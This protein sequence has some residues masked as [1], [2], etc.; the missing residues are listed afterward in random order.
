MCLKRLISCHNN[1]RPI[2]PLCFPDSTIETRL[3]KQH[4]PGRIAAKV[5]ESK[6]ASLPVTVDHG[7]P[8]SRASFLRRDIKSQDSAIFMLVG[9]EMSTYSGKLNEG[10]VLLLEWSLS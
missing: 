9:E 8:N 5:G 2:P 7:D 10:V 6:E 4:E 1:D 3:T